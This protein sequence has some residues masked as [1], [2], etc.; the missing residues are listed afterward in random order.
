MDSEIIK[1]YKNGL[2]MVK[3]AKQ[4]KMS[5]IRV[6]KILEKNNIMIRRLG[7]KYNL[8][9]RTEFVKD[10]NEMRWYELEKKYDVSWSVIKYWKKRFKLT[11]G[12][13]HDRAV[14]WR[15][16]KGCW[17]CSSHKSNKGYPRGRGG[18]LI[19]KRN[20]EEL[21]G[22]SWPDGKMTRHLCDTKWCINPDHVV[23]GTAFENM[24]DCVLD[25]RG[26]GRIS[27]KYTTSM[28][29]KALK[30]NI[31]AIAEDGRVVRTVD[32]VVYP[33]KCSDLKRKVV[34]KLSAKFE[35]IPVDSQS[36][37]VSNGGGS[38]AAIG[39]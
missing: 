38:T 16:V 7:Q 1:L 6:R 31:I 22:M 25:G 20:W 10:C 29:L 14:M 19:V 37:G 33:I 30:R 32:A 35:R 18:V 17:K 8:P 23:P 4:L 15:D 11:D 28:L 13:K 5:N 27:E 2:S 12:V 26:K 39:C 34:V 36:K 3:I 24:V 21:H 9:D